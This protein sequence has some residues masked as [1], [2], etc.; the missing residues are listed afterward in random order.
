MS[1]KNVLLDYNHIGIL[2]YWDTEFDYIIIGVFA[3][4]LSIA[5]FKRTPF[6]R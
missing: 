2:F 6:A 1:W 5:P 4:K 3:E